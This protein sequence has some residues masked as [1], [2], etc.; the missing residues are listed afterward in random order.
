MKTKILFFLFFLFIDN[1][2]LI[3]QNDFVKGSFI[4]SR[5]GTIYQTV[6]IDSLIWMTEN[7]NFTTEESHCPNFSKSI[8]EC[9]NGNFYRFEEISNVCPQSFR[10][11]Y[12]YE[13]ENYLLKMLELR[14]VPEDSIYFDEFN[15]DIGSWMSDF[16]YKTNIFEEPNIIKISKTGHIQGKKLKKDDSFHVW[17]R[18]L[19]DKNKPIH[20]HIF[21]NWFTAHNHKH[22]IFVRRKKKRR[23][24]S[25]RCVKVITDKNSAK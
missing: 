5:D 20:Y 8:E 17:L 7:L 24:F 15:S 16:T 14:G 12:V 3:A 22:H 6:T 11:P 10:L 18:S 13:F 21:E 25:V 23:K 1:S 19:E 2:N 9:N 4:D